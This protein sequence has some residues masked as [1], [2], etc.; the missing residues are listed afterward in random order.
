MGRA[1]LLCYRV[2]QQAKYAH[3][4]QFLHQQLALQPRTPSGGFWHKQ[5]YPNQMWLD[6]AYM[7][8][9]FRAEYAVT[10]QTPEDFD[11]IAQA[12]PPHGR[13]HARPAHRAAAPRLGREQ[14][15][16]PGPTRPPASP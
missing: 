12:A 15:A 7:A 10:F 9:P 16:C 13:P 5:V 1:V 6:G 11:D 3:A 14:A 4:A 8:E 2:T